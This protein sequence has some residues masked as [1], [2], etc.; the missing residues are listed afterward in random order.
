M[1][2]SSPM[3]RALAGGGHPVR[4]SYPAED[5]CMLASAFSS[6]FCQRYAQRSLNFT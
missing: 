2:R 3:L 6:T 1:G 4:V 5:C